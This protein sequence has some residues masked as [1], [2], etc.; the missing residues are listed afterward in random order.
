MNRR[1]LMIE[2]NPQN[3]YLAGF[4]LEASGWEM[5]HAED[6]PSGLE[7]ARTVDPVLILLDIQLPGMDG[8]AVAQAL[9]AE[10]GSAGVPIVA[11]TS[12]AMAGD[13]ERCLAAGCDGY[14]EKPIDPQTFVALVERFV[15]EAG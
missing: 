10:P 5:V 3:R 13:R 12:Y 6:G 11:V 7:L 4:L 1:I 15:P 2:D 8:Y 14:I 9:R